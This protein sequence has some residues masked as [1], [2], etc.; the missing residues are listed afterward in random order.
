MSKRVNEFFIVDVL[1]A[2]N[3]IKSY[4]KDFSDA[5]T[6]LHDEKSFD[7]TMRELE[8]VGEATKH[9]LRDE[10]LG[11]QWQI[12]VDFR[13]IIIH[14]YFGIE[15]D[16]IWEVITVHLLEFETE[17][18]AALKAMDKDLLSRLLKSALIDNKHSQIT[19]ILLNKLIQDSEV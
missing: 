5:D 13:N 9:L 15:I 1:I 6:F 2:V 8:I 4:T 19:T 3:K 10:L 7:A 14:E 12:V 18:I 11:K 17:V 16:E